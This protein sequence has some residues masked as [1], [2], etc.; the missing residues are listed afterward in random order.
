LAKRAR[1]TT[2]IGALAINTLVLIWTW[3]DW[4]RFAVALG[5]YAV[6]FPLNLLV[7]RLVAKHGTSTEVGRALMN[8]AICAV[9]YQWIGWPL[10][11]WLWM[12]FMPLA[13]D[14]I[15]S[16]Q[17]L[18]V[19]AISC[20]VQDAAAIAGGVSPGIPIVFTM[21]AV[22]T[23]VLVNA[24]VQIIREMLVTADERGDE[25]AR[26]SVLV[27]ARTRQMRLVF[28]QVDQG[29]LLIDLDG[30]IATEHSAIVE[31]WLGPMPESLRI[32]DLIRAFAPS[33]AD[34]FELA[35]EALGDGLVP[36]ELAVTQLPSRFE[37]GG[38]KLAWSYKPFDRRV[39][40]V[41]TD[42]TDAIAHADDERRER[43]LTSLLSRAVRDQTAFG[44]AFD[45]VARLVAAVAVDRN[46]ASYLR[47]VHTLKGVAGI[48]DLVTIAEAC[49]ELETTIADGDSVRAR[50]LRTTIESRWH[51]LAAFAEPFLEQARDR[52]D[53]SETDVAVVEAKLARGASIAELSRA[54]ADWRDDRVAARLR[55]LA[56]LARS[57]AT[58]LGKQPL[59]IEIDCA[60]ELRLPQRFAPLWPALCHVVRNAV[61]HGIESCDVRTA[62]GKPAAA[63]LTLRATAH[64]SALVIDIADDGRGID[65]DRV[66][67]AAVARG[68]PASTHGELEAALFD[69]GVSTSEQVSEISGRGVGL[70][71]MRATAAQLGAIVSA[72][73][74]AGRGTSIAVELPIDPVQ[75]RRTLAG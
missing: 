46:G 40:V 55:L 73:S 62:N 35:W 66:K 20:G 50:D 16:R 39:L 65:W 56:D 27:E 64:D 2:N 43:E 70:A 48:I 10:P 22:M 57:L 32:G 24:R 45:E 17:S 67:A 41:I 44:T 51:E 19:L 75:R 61:D 1:R 74:R 8:Q 23:W 52:L 7:D 59:E 21:L 34:W 28:D 5:L 11:V 25:L 33:R 30:T 63:R 4:H 72:T 53:V 60:T 47:D 3:G 68:L 6:I 37:V 9:A 71:A 13:F 38:R 29:L 26:L 15:G 49:H 54:L 36:L 18:L 31:R 14:S 12:P 42:V 69:D 58:R